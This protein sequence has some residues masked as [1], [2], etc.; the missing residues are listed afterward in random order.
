MQVHS[1]DDHL[2]ISKPVIG[3]TSGQW[4]VQLSR[5][6]TNSD[7]SFGGVVVVSLNPEHFTNFY[8]KIDF[9]SAASIAMIGGDGVVRASGGSAAGRFALG[10]DLTGTSLL[11]AFQRQPQFNLR[12]QGRAGPAN[13]VDGAA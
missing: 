2:F 13:D 12:I 10:Q 7:G 6:F 5:R 8:D 3:R 1:T 4:S 11:R 9:G